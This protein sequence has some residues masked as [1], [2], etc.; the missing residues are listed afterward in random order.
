[1]NELHHVTAVEN[2]EDKKERGKEGVQ[3][4]G[5]EDDT[6]IFALPQVVEI[7]E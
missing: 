3:K 7:L 4:E 1:M 2:T 5:G 6:K